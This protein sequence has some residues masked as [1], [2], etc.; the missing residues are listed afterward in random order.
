MQSEGEGTI[1]SFTVEYE[2]KPDAP[3]SPEEVESQ[4]REELIRVVLAGLKHYVETG[5]AFAASRKVPV[6]A[7]RG[8]QT[9]EFPA[10]I[11]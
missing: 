10:Y 9:K 11:F 3:V 2:L 1:A 6:Y 8:R 5:W 7:L 4:N